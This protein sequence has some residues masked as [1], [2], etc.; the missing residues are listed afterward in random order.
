MSFAHQDFA[1]SGKFLWKKKQK[2]FK[3]SWYVH[4]FKTYDMKQYKVIEITTDIYLILRIGY[5]LEFYFFF[6]QKSYPCCKVIVKT[7]SDTEV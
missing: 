1:K 3:F 6:S 5:T 4:P 7:Q 2:Q